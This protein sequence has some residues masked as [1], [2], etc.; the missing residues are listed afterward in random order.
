MKSQCFRM[1]IQISPEFL[2]KWR[3]L[4]KWVSFAPPSLRAS[5]FR[6]GARSLGKRKL[7]LPRNDRVLSYRM[8]R[9]EGEGEG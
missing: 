8:G 1:R 2:E 5:K 9:E 7:F 6:V 3:Y 4:G